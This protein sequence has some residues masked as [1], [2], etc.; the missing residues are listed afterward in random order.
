MLCI[1]ININK[2]EGKSFLSSGRC[3]KLPPDDQ[4]KTWIQTWT[5]NCKYKDGTSSHWFAIFC[6][7]SDVK[8]CTFLA[9]Q[10][11][12]CTRMLHSYLDHISMHTSLMPSSVKENTSIEGQ[13]KFEHKKNFGMQSHF[14]ILTFRSN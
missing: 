4:T 10:P 13:R 11:C 8:P 3:N 5:S 14:N 2:F 6:M 12:L 1:Y 9:A 7:S